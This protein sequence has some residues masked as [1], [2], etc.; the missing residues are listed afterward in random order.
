MQ[1]TIAHSY[2]LISRSLSLP[3][4][5]LPCRVQQA[6]CS[7]MDTILET[8]TVASRWL[9]VRNLGTDRLGAPLEDDA[10]GDQSIL[11]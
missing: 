3:S 7:C 11:Q 4:A 10:D 5:Y 9:G 2:Q 1:P 8:S 6:S